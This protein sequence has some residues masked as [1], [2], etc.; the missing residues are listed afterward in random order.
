MIY[1][2]IYGSY[3]EKIVLQVI[4]IICDTLANYM[5]SVHCLQHYVCYQIYVV[6]SFKCLSACYVIGPL[7]T[8]NYVNVCKKL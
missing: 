4:M 3:L 2:N 1:D 5:V 8:C 7:E 6:L